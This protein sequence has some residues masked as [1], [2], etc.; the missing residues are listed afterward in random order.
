MSVRLGVHGTY[1][2][3]VDR[4]CNA[5]NAF[6]NDPERVRLL[7]ANTQKRSMLKVVGMSHA[8]GVFAQGR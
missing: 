6:A 8:K 1:D 4:C 3:I 2:D 7:R 5:W